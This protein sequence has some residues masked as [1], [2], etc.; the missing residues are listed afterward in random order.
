MRKKSESA[1]AGL[2]LR[3]E[4]MAALMSVE[5]AVAGALVQALCARRTGEAGPE[6]PECAR[7]VFQIM[8]TKLD[9]DARHYE[10]VCEARA[11]AARQRGKGKTEGAGNTAPAP[12][13]EQEAEQE[14][15]PAK[16]PAKKTRT[17]KV[18]T[19]KPAP[20]P[21]PGVQELVEC[22][23]EYLEPVVHKGAMCTPGTGKEARIKAAI[24]RYGL[25]RIKDAF[26]KLAE[27]RGWLT[28]QT[29]LTFEWPFD[30]HEYLER[31]LQGN[32][33]DKSTTAKSAPVKPETRRVRFQM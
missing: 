24:E 25:E 16:K 21:D 27:D 14:A 7:L 26:K 3:P 18:A 30:N 8:A 31:I 11:E 2:V 19:P 4:W 15:E 1:R 5:P 20:E 13:A 12:E 17:R 10:S 28:Q 6:V 33:N 29:F 32:Y 9:E 23:I 22:W